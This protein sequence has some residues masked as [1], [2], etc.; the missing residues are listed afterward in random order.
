MRVIIWVIKSLFLNTLF[1]LITVATDCVVADIFTLDPK[2]LPSLPGFLIFSACGLWIMCSEHAFCCRQ[3]KDII[4]SLTAFRNL[5]RNEKCCWKSLALE[6]LRLWHGMIS[7]QAM[8]HGVQYTPLP[9]PR[10]KLQSGN[11][12]RNQP[13]VMLF[14]VVM[15]WRRRAFA[16]SF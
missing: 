5:P 15:R 6:E 13:L 8:A 14:A 7:T 9:A 4:P 10:L 11:Q 16:A 2:K 3:N 12:S 1:G